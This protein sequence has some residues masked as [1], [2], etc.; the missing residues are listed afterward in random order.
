M[1]PSESL[2]YSHYL[3]KKVAGSDVL[4]IITI[5]CGLFFIAFGVVIVA[6]AMWSLFR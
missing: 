6:I 4:K 5:Y 3:I 1:D 2:F